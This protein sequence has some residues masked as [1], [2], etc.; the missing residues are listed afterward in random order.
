MD[1]SPQ[2]TPTRKG[3]RVSQIVSDIEVLASRLSGGSTTANAGRISATGS[4]VQATPIAQRRGIEI[5]PTDEDMRKLN[6]RRADLARQLSGRTTIMDFASLLKYLGVLSEFT[7]SRQCTSDAFAHIAGHVPSLGDKRLAAH[8]HGGTLVGPKSSNEAGLVDYFKNLWAEMTAAAIAWNSRLAVDQPAIPMPHCELFDHQNTYIPASRQKADIVFYQHE[9]QEGFQSIHTILEAKIE[10]FPGGELPELE[11]GQIADYALSVWEAQPMRTFVPIFYLHGRNLSLFVF[12]RNGIVRV[13]LGA[14]CHNKQPSSA[15]IVSDTKIASL[16]NTMRDLWFLLTLPPEK[17]G[18]L[19][20]TPKYD[21]YL[22]F[23]KEPSNPVLATKMT[24]N[25][26]EGTFVARMPDCTKTRI[27]GRLAFVAKV[28]YGPDDKAAVLKLTWTP[29]KRL[30]EA[31]VYDLLHEGGVPNIPAIYESGILKKDFFGYRLEYI[32]TEDC[33]N[34]IIEFGRKSY[35]RGRTSEAAGL[36][37]KHVSQV[38]SSLVH[39]QAVGLFHRDISSGNIAI[40]SED[41]A[42]VIDWGYAKLVATDSDEVMERNKAILRKWE[43]DLKLI[44]RSE[45]NTD[46]LTGTLIY[47][48]LQMLVSDMERGLIHDV[49][50]LFYVMLHVLSDLNGERPRGFRVFDSTDFAWARVGYLSDPNY[51]YESFGVEINGV[52]EK[53]R[54]VLDA[55]YKFLFM[56]SD[57]YIGGKL[58]YVKNFQRELSREHAEKFMDTD[59]LQMILPDH[60]DAATDESMILEKRKS[61]AEEDSHNKRACV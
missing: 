6:D 54:T 12:T 9:G 16:C 7:N 15:S 31:A 1:F 34:D 60:D 52:D 48:S 29:A 18:H 35:A 59:A 38:T 24:W 4:N 32:I 50:S 45:P 22:V 14:I 11:R 41:N 28:Q 21:K 5:H 20:D 58:L 39:A 42:I 19:C 37:A 61:G 8:P 57:R 51:F 36:A 40:N 33:G 44:L 47:I 30:S 53:L 2:G 55:M 3:L 17:F 56:Q 26:K 46:M 23:E 27:I 49:E 13:D 25:S 43:L 10:S